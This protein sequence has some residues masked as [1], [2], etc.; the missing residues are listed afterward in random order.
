MALSDAGGFNLPYINKEAA[1]QYLIA[2]QA[3]KI[4]QPAVITIKGL[5]PLSQPGTRDLYISVIP[6]NMPKYT[7][8]MPSGAGKTSNDEMLRS[9][10]RKII[11]RLDTRPT[12]KQQ[13]YAGSGRYP[14]DKYPAL[15]VDQLQY[16]VTSGE[17]KGGTL[18][19][20]LSD[21]Y[22]TREM[23]DEALPSYRVRVFHDTGLQEKAIDKQ[24]GQVKMR[25]VLEAQSAFGFVATHQGDLTGWRHDLIFDDIPACPV[26]S[27]A[28]GTCYRKLAPNVYKVSR[29]PNDGSIRVT[30]YVEAVEPKPWSIGLLLGAAIPTGPFG[31]HAKAGPATTLTLER[32]WM[33]FNWPPMISAAATLG[34][35]RMPGDGTQP[36]P[37]AT[38]RDVGVGLKVYLNQPADWRVYAMPMVDTYHF[39]NGSTKSGTSLALGLQYEWNPAWALDLR[40]GAHRISSNAPQSSFSTLQAGVRYSF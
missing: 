19:Q 17:I 7:K 20:L 26:A 33:A 29:L 22:V 36:L 12:L 4:E 27:T 18:R 9:E 39:S 1:N 3:S 10:I 14:D 37:D 23:I 21:G 8:R 40:Y 31:D 5:K 2:L 6:S 32:E 25:D 28:A 13:Q 34:I 24:S 30:T 35:A 38:V 16:G 15:T 11:E